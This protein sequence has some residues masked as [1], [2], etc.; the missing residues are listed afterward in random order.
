MSIPDIAF[1]APF[2]RLSAEDG[3]E[4]KTQSFSYCFVVY[5]WMV[6]TFMKMTPDSLV[7]SKHIIF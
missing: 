1:D 3:K 7:G 5:L 2:I 6:M 4:D